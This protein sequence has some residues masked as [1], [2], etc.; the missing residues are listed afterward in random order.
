[1][2][3]NKSI[4]ERIFQAIGFECLAI[5]ICTPLLAWI[6]QKP[7]LEMGAVTVLIA[8]LALGWNVVFNRFFDM[9]IVFPGLQLRFNE[10]RAR[11]PEFVAAPRLGL[12]PHSL[13]AVPPDAL[14]DAIEGLTALDATAPIHIHIAEQTAEVDA[15][16]AW[17][18]QRPVKR[19]ARFSTNER[20]PSRASS[21][22][23][24]CGISSAC[25]FQRSA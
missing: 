3:A 2:T 4:T 22:M 16:L 12:A 9:G 25:L 5:L 8:L 17:S 24:T 13:R 15:C 20:T 7:M 11:W 19:A 10:P 18:G 23:K 21:L 1:M 6:M 14:R